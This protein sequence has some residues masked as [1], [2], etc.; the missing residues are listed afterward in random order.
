MLWAA[1]GAIFAGLIWLSGVLAAP[2]AKPEPTA[3]RLSGR[4]LIPLLKAHSS[5]HHFSKSTHAHPSCSVQVHNA[6]GRLGFLGLFWAHDLISN[7]YQF[8]V[9]LRV[10]GKE[11]LAHA[12]TQQLFVPWIQRVAMCTFLHLPTWH[13]HYPSSPWERGEK[14]L[15]KITGVK[16]LEIQTTRT[17]RKCS[18]EVSLKPRGA[19][20][21]FFLLLFLI[22]SLL[23]G[24]MLQS[25]LMEKDYMLN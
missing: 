5:K 6:L 11:L 8:H 21:H 1:S 16:T 4:G 20:S 23:D 2:A 25:I 10:E 13:V 15:C 9:S 14:L 18:I 7:D 22:S 12:S 24:F 3:H 19:H 17:A